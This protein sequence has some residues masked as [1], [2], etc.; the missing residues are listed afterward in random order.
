[1]TINDTDRSAIADLVA[2]FA[3][4]I[5][6]EA[7]HGVEDLFTED[8]TYDLAGWSHTGREALR[9]S[10]RMRA[11]QGPRTSRH[12][13]TNLRVRSSTTSDTATGTCV[14]TLHARDGRPPHPLS[15]VMVA[16]YVDTYH[17]DID[18]NWRF[19]TRI[20]SIVFVQVPDDAAV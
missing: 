12:I 13:F 19:G 4:R 2:E 5:D 6:H 14:L 7:G 9:R 18:G 15:P 10:Y 1:M 3:W 8:G 17:R 11:A 20:V 16:D